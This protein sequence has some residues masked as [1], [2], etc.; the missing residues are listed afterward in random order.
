MRDCFVWRE[1]TGLDRKSVDFA[2]AGLDGF[3]SNIGLSEAYGVER[4]WED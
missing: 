2:S 3:M 1:R 4:R